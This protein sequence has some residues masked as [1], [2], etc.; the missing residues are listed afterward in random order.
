MLIV[1]ST[2]FKPSHDWGAKCWPYSQWKHENLRPSRHDFGMILGTPWLGWSHGISNLP[3]KTG[4]GKPETYWNNNRKL[5]AIGPWR[6][7]Q[8][9]QDMVSLCSYSPNK[10]AAL[11]TWT[12]RGISDLLADSWR[13]AAA[14]TIGLWVT[15]FCLSLSL[16]M[17]LGFGKP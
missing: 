2:Y 16:M 15:G 13:R 10:T 8:D 14:W 11:V 3:P 7:S 5:R 12:H 17:R 6:C 4:Y 9:S 1:T